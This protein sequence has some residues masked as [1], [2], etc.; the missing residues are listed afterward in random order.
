M[1]D[2]HRKGEGQSLENAYGSPIYGWDSKSFLAVLDMVPLQ[3]TQTNK[4]T[5]T[6]NDVNVSVEKSTGCYRS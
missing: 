6:V 4:G 5:I 1:S 2:G 3:L